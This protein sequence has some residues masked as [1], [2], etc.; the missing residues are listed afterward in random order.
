LSECEN[1]ALFLFIQNQRINT[2]ISYHTYAESVSRPWAWSMS[3]AP[4]NNLLTIMCDTIASMITCQSGSGHY[5]SFQQSSW[6]QICGEWNDLMYG[7]N[8]YIKGVPCYPFTIELGTSVAP[9]S[10]YLPQICRENFK[11]LVYLAQRIDSVVSVTP[12]IVVAPEIGFQQ[13]GNNYTVYWIPR[14]ETSV[15]FWRLWEMKDMSV[16][17]DTFGTTNTRWTFSGFNPSTQQAHSGSYSILANYIDGYLAYAKTQYPYLV[18][19]GDTASFWTYYDL[20]SNGDVA[21]FEISADGLVWHQIFR[22]TG[23]QPFWHSLSYPLDDYAGKSLYFRF[24]LSTDGNDR[25]AG[26]YIDDFYPAVDYDSINLSPPLLDTFYQF[27]NVPYGTYFYRAQGYNNQGPGI[28]SQLIRVDV[29]VGVAET[30]AYAIIEPSILPTIIRNFP[31]EGM[32][33]TKIYNILGQRIKAIE[34]PGIYFVET[35]QKYTKIIVIK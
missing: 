2:G 10:I 11:A 5:D 21:F 3:P 23:Y 9:D 32:S 18:E 28:Q 25:Y 33:A 15:N 24:R 19:Q 20:E 34:K 22:L 30:K 17:V 31:L 6:Y 26:I 13:S 14:T 27:T 8:R 29:P 7:Y 16:I 1:Q 4:D 12:R 35:D